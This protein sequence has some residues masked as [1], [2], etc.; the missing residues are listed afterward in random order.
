MSTA[1][2]NM[3][4]FIREIALFI[5]ICVIS[6]IRLKAQPAV[7]S[8][9]NSFDTWRKDNLQEKIFAHTD[10]DQYLAGEIMWF[11]LYYVD[12]SFHRPLHLSNIA[13][14]ELIDESNKPVSQSSLSLNTDGANGSL[15]IPKNLA[16]G[17][18]R[19]RSY[20]RWMKNYSADYFFEKTIL[21]YHP[22]NALKDSSA[23]N[24]ISYDLG[25]FPEA[26]DLVNGIESRVAFHLTNQYG[27]GIQS[28]GWL[29]NDANDTL[30]QIESARFGMGEFSLKPEQ[31]KKY[32]AMLLL[33]DGS[34]IEKLIPD[35]HPTGVVLQVK[36][37]NE[38]I[39]VYIKTNDANTESIFL[40]AHTRGIVN[41]AS[42]VPVIN[43]LGR[44]NIDKRSL[45]EGITHI[46]VF[47]NLRP[48]CE[49]LIFSYPRRQVFI[50]AVTDTAV[51]ETREKIKINI[52]SNTEAD[53]PNLA[54]LSLAVIR[55]DDLNQPSENEINIQNYLLLSSDLT[56]YIENP[57]WCFDQNNSEKEKTMDLL[58]MTH[59]W[60]RFQ[61]KD[62]LASEKPIFSFAPEIHG[63]ILSVRVTDKLSGLVKDD[64]P[65]YLS[66]LG[67]ETKFWSSVTDEKGKADFELK[68]YFGKGE[69]VLQSPDPNAR[70]EFISPFSNIQSER[71]FPPIAVRSE[72]TNAI[73]RKSIY[74]QVQD[75]YHKKN[76]DSFVTK[77]QPPPFYEKPDVVYLLDRY[78][79][80]SS[81]EEVMREYVR[82]VNVVNPSTGF[83]LHVM[84]QL[85]KGPFL[86][87]PLILLD[88]LPILDV[89]SFMNFDPLKV[90]SINVVT[91]KY[92]LG[93]TSFNGI[94]DCKTYKGDLD[95]YSLDPKILTVNFDGLQEHREF[96][97]PS[98][99]SAKDRASR[100]PDFR[101]L[102]Y[103]NPSIK[104]ILGQESTL[105]CYSSD[106]PGK[107][108][109]IVQG[110]SDD[111][112]PLFYRTFF[113]VKRQDSGITKD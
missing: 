15:E 103:W 20:T 26:G 55:T 64:I 106:I 29:L 93:N 24:A 92:Y 4:P 36:E 31:G 18:Y 96:Y 22:Q 33:P 85:T 38:K 107:Y 67:K 62:I 84:N 98:Y 91:K 34:T 78:T 49:R 43:G 109:L 110:I 83:H 35:A 50:R 101:T 69:F 113:S 23:Q 104:V 48:I 68:D 70:I 105:E 47:Q 95:G 89:N 30:T 41:V 88:G 44:L 6:H 28:R 27:Q 90:K 108:D 54:H 10:K 14:V 19:F 63:A 52:I 25:I 12:A 87:D 79:R 2:K 45:D 77:V 57:G 65:V 111:G 71:H 5:S 97:Q 21:I 56:G 72:S 17:Y 3:I 40:F 80:F 86:T 81:M 76:L 1:L 32:K 9:V 102:L 8:P 112:T 58:M 73:V 75:V 99:G 37:N 11:K 51:Y 7:A 100:M 46:T 59:G 74:E 42:S 94:I 60:R 61:W 82:E 39:E 16:S 53:T 66:V 13:Y